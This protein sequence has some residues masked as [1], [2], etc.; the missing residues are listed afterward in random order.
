SLSVEEQNA[1][2]LLKTLDVQSESGGIAVASPSPGRGLAF[3]YTPP[4]DFVG[5]D[6]LTGLGRDLLGNEVE[7]TI[8][9][10]VVQ[11]TGITI[12][13]AASEL[14]DVI[15]VA[16]STSGLS[17]ISSFNFQVG[18]DPAV[19]KFAGTEFGREFPFLAETRINQNNRVNVSALG[20]FSRGSDLVTLRFERLGEGSAAIELLSDDFEASVRGQSLIVLAGFE[21]AYYYLSQDDTNR[22]GAVTAR[23][24]LAVVNR[25]SLSPSG[26]ENEATEPV[27]QRE[28]DTNGDGVNTARDALRIV[29]RLGRENALESASSLAATHPIFSES[30]LRFLDPDKEIPSFVGRPGLP[31][32]DGTP[33]DSVDLT[34]PTAEEKSAAEVIVLAPDG[35]S[36]PRSL[37][38]Q[39]DQDLFVIDTSGRKLGFGLSAIIDDGHPNPPVTDLTLVFF[40]EDGTVIEAYPDAATGRVM[41]GSID[42]LAGEK[43]YVRVGTTDARTLDY[44]LEF[45]ELTDNTEEDPNLL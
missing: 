21:Q 16:I 36:I 9:I 27:Y 41:I 19:V 30:G 17:H 40:R 31:I 45:L 1:W 37:S 24:A 39:Q 34:P 42:T 3:R 6:T 5:T 7:G 20:G 35:N 11:S 28:F 38:S 8:T 29:N 25:L 44:R 33:L 23:D 32:D 4:A 10:D 13:V 14:D 15:E 2:A 18:F 43:V 26:A 12:N 22:D